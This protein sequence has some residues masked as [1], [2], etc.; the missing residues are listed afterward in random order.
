MILLICLCIKEYRSGPFRDMPECVSFYVT[1][2]GG[3][4]CLAVPSFP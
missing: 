1:C 2:A 4:V 3:S